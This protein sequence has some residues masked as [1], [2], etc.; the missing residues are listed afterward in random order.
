MKEAWLPSRFLAIVKD[1]LSNSLIFFFH[2]LASLCFHLYLVLLKPEQIFK[3]VNEETSHGEAEVH[4]PSSKTSELSEPEV[5]F[6][7]L[8]T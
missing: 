8:Y 2:I 3:I 6:S 1:I 4:V 7:S 5:F